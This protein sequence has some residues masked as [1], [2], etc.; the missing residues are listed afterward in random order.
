M[1]YKIIYSKRK[2]LGLTV[3]DGELTVRAPKG[4]SRERIEDAVKSHRSW[5]ET[6]IERSRSKSDGYG[7]LSEAEIYKLKSDA[8]LYFNEKC[9]YYSEIMGVS[10]Q[11][12]KITSAKRRFGSC[13]SKGNICFSYFLM[14]YPEKAREYVVIHELAH[15]SEMNHSEKFYRIVSRYMPDYKSAAALL[16]SIPKIQ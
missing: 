2:T 11:G 12:P 8:K 5:I 7:S 9:R 1:E 16:K 10:Y 14:L 15:R 6:H 3:K 4:L 13:S